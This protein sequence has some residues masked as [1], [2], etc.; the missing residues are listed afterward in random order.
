MQ[1]DKTPPRYF[2]FLP[3][4]VQQCT[5]RWNPKWSGL[6]GLSAPR[7]PPAHSVT[8]GSVSSESTTMQSLISSTTAKGSTPLPLFLLSLAPMEACPK[9]SPPLAPKQS[10]RPTTPCHASTDA[11]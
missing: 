2:Y 3:N 6:G 10:G 9:R 8:P 11:S 5:G 7:A 4:K 1:Q